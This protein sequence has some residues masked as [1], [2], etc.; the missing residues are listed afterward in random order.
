MSADDIWNK[1]RSL[2]FPIFG[3]PNQKVEGHFNRLD[4]PGDDRV[5]LTAK[6]GSALP[7][8]EEV[9]GTVYTV[10]QEDRYIIISDPNP[11][12]K[13]IAVAVKEEKADKLAAK[14]KKL[15]AK[16]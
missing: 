3:L 5:F 1:I 8:L 13:K 9:L 12:P 7:L 10:S 16:K 15:T 2:P 14:V 4:I 11:L 6:A